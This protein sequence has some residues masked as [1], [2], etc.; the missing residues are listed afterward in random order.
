[1]KRLVISLLIAVSLVGCAGKS[2][3]VT[4]R[5]PGIP[6]DLAKT[7]P[8]LE[9][10]D[11]NTNKLSDVLN[12]VTDNYISYYECKA[13][14]DDWMEWYRTQKTIFDKVGK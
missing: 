1:M 14:V 11:A 8:D 7:C 2:V 5:F 12:T 6:L 10:V 13:K 4:V 9:T 3:P